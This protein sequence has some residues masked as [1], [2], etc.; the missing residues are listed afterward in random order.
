MLAAQGPEAGGT[1]QSVEQVNQL[2]HGSMTVELDAAFRN[3][4]LQLRG[5]QAL[6]VLE[7]I[8]MVCWLSCTP[9]CRTA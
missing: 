1:E 9:S 3:Y 8:Q 7:A 4:V 2:R 6:T 5:S